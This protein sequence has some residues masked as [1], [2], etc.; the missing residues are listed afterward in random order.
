MGF[1]HIDTVSYLLNM[2]VQV[3]VNSL[4][5]S[6]QPSMDFLK[7]LTQMGDIIPAHGLHLSPEKGHQGEHEH[8]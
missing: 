1:C 8:P 3:R 5:N 2:R 4:F 7:V 6:L